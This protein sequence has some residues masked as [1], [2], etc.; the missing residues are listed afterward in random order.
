MFSKS[1]I[2]R[3]REN[4]ARLRDGDN[5][6]PE[7]LTSETSGNALPEVFNLAASFH[8]ACRA[9]IPARR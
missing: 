2:I 8:V 6:K 7:L 3:A 5:A 1:C 9:T 4:L